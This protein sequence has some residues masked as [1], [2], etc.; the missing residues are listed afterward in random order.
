[1]VVYNLTNLQNLSGLPALISVTNEASN[2]LMT[3]LFII[4]VW[5]VLLFAFLR[6][7]FIKAMATSS[8]ICFILSTFLVYL[9]LLNIMFLLVFL[10]LTAGAGLLMYLNED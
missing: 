4:A 10:F 6:F 2:G 7:D 8:F 3:G 9:D 1:M 5:V